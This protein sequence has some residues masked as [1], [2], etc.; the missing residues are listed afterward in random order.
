MN[1]KIFRSVFLSMILVLTASMVLITAILNQHYVEVEKERMAVEAELVEAGI[2]TE[3]MAYLEAVQEDMYRLTWIARD[4]TVLFDSQADASQMEN[5]AGREEFQGALAEGS[6]YSSRKSDTL[7]KTTIYYAKQMTDG[8]VVRVAITND[9]L[10]STF[11]RMTSAFL[12]VLLAAVA[13]SVFVARRLSNRI[14][15]PLNKIDLDHPLEMREYPEL[16]PMLMR[17][18]E[19]NKE[20]SDQIETLHRQQKEF[21]A[22]T[23]SIHEGLIL[24]DTS[25][26]ILSMNEMAVR[27]F[28][29]EGKEV[30]ELRELEPQ[31]M[32]EGL[33]SKAEQRAHSEEILSRG[34]R[35]YRVSADPITSRGELTGV[36]L[37]SYDV[38][39]EQEE[40]EHRQEFTANV[41]H[42]LKTP[43]QSI[44]GSAELLENG[45]VRKEDEPV[46]LHRIRTESA[47]MLTLIDDIIRLSQ[48]DTTQDVKTDNVNL[49]NPVLEALEALS[50]SA[51]DH[52]VTIQRELQP[53]IVRG[54][55]RLL[56]E[57]AYNL[58][59][60]AIRYNKDPGTVTVRTYEKGGIAFLQ[61]S[62]TGVG[63][64]RES[65]NRIFERFYRVDKSRSRKTGGTGLGLSIV[66]HAVQLSGGKVHLESKVGSG[67]TFTVTIPGAA[68]G[69]Q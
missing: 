26:H 7:T 52:H 69:K 62:D 40:E 10:L 29:P 41:S 58:V 18:D 1:K 24:L 54:N 47:R 46:F 30:K 57:I 27:L 64:P 43:L 33:V 53:V 34:R 35:R 25:H 51:Q 21:N 42:E 48:L 6:A 8:T 32:L 37:L 60:N 65:Q 16:T 31:D 13:A 50:A 45:M 59:D 9:S 36:S 49:E 55:A 61:V 15:R 14:V 4:G 23:H 12:W 63:I 67:S 17:I 11:F 28:S 44:M 68:D 39:E 19:Q 20:I 38:T 56:Y 3:G 2:E 22:V 66:K 5:H